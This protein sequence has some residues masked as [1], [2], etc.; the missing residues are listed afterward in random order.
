MAVDPGVSSLFR[1]NLDLRFK[2]YSMTF[3]L[4]GNLRYLLSMLLFIFF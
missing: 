1:L 3:D 4:H 2:I